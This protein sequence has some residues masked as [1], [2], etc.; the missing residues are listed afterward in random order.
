ML[1]EKRKSIQTLHCEGWCVSTRTTFIITNSL[2]EFPYAL[3]EL[4]L[5][6]LEDIA[7]TLIHWL[8]S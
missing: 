3:V 2:V 6:M 5:K 1:V 8:K 4:K 7:P